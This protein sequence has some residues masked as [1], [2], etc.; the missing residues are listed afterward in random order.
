MNKESKKIAWLMVLGQFF[1]QSSV[2]IVVVVSFFFDKMDQGMLIG[3]DIGS[4]LANVVILGFFYLVG[5]KRIEL[6]E[7][8]KQGGFRIV[9]V[10][11]AVILVWNL[12]IGT[13]DFALS[14]ISA[15]V[16]ESG[17]VPLLF[18]LI[19]IGVLPALFEEFAFRKVIYGSMR[20]Y[21]PV[22]AAAFSSTLFGLM[23]QDLTQG[24]FAFGMGLVL[25]YV[26]EKTGRL[27]YTI[28]LH[29]VNNTIS[30]LLPYIPRY[31]EFGGSIEAFLGVLAMTCILVT[32]LI[33]G[34]RKKLVTC[35]QPAFQVVKSRI[36]ECF[37]TV[38]MGI[39][40]VICIGMTI[41]TA[42][43]KYGGAL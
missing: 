3:A 24:I 1:F 2:F 34:V 36:R 37:V 31:R 9:P 17:P 40:A 4:F 16:D 6:P 32:L 22:V 8:R 23:H 13:F 33:P 7:V 26:Y 11:L 18:S 27:V 14:R 5:R 42:I 25:C 29:F 39:Y 35:F 21:G 20:K 12:M 30:V 41:V 28:L 19:T 15:P 43:I 10:A 38:P